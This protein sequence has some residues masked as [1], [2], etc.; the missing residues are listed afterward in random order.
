MRLEKNRSRD[1]CLEVT[2]GLRVHVTALKE[3]DAVLK[4]V[5][6]REGTTVEATLEDNIVFHNDSELD[7]GDLRRR[8]RQFGG[9]FQLKASKSEIWFPTILASSRRMIF[10]C[11][12]H[13]WR[14]PSQDYCDYDRKEGRVEVLQTDRPILVR[15][16]PV[17][18][19]APLSDGDTIRIDAGQ[20]LR[21]NFT[22]RLLEEERNII[23]S[24]EVRDL[25]CRFR[26]GQVAIDGISFSVQ[27][28]EM[29]CV[30]GASGAERAP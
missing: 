8:A 7:L 10:C 12:R 2:F 24:L 11:P 15:G 25:V 14:C 20:V 13:R 29:V 5:R 19:F 26:N 30:M 17:R 4:G 1:S 16:V 21:C 23:R 22:E 18:N 3:V 27:R 6:L 28:G 9:R